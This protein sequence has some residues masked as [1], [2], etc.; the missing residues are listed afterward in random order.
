MD[1]RAFLGHAAALAGTV[2][3]SALAVTLP[4]PVRRTMRVLLGFTIRVL[5][6]PPCA[7]GRVAMK[8]PAPWDDRVGA[9]ANAV[10]G[11]VMSLAGPGVGEFESAYLDRQTRRELVQTG[12]TGLVPT[13]PEDYVYVDAEG[14]PL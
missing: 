7:L 10:L 14:R 1:R 5:S 6:W 2:G 4:A 12:W 9:L 8:L 3:I 11:L 13:V